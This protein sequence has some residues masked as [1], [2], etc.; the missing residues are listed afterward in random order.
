MLWVSGGSGQVGRALLGGCREDTVALDREDFDFSDPKSLEEKLNQLGKPPRA[1]INAAAYTQVDRAETESEL[2]FKVNAEAPEQLARWCAK[3]GVLLV[4][5]STDYV[6]SGEG[7]RPWRETDKT[8]P[9]NAYGRS[10]LAGEEA[11]QRSGANFVILR[12]SW[13]YDAFG[14]NFLK[15]M[16]NL[17]KDR[18]TLR[19]VADQIGAPT[20]APHLA[21]VTF[22]VVRAVLDDKKPAGLYHLCNGGQTSWHGFAE[23][24][25]AQARKQG[26]E[27][28]V[29]RVEPIRTEEYPSP[30]ARPKNSRL[31]TEKAFQTWG[32]RLPDWK[33]GLNECLTQVTQKQEDPPG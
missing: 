25:F 32:V 29:N 7:T 28:K 6:F 21:R 14:K 24:I 18:E 2:A 8:G 1:L 33:K 20:Y 5:F 16:L 11:I 12:T 9:K 22:D 23:E 4:H 30:A 31:D 27:L 13:V 3:N 19:V 15:T 17:G 10:K 26:L